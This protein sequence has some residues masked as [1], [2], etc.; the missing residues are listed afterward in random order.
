MGSKRLTPE[1]REAVLRL[2][3][4]GQSIGA[5]ARQAGVSRYSASGIISRA[6]ERRRPGSKGGRP[7]TPA[8]KLACIVARYRAGATLTEA[9]AGN[10][11][12]VQTAWLYLKQLG[13][14]RKRGAPSESDASALLALVRFGATPWE[15]A[16]AR[17]LRLGE[18]LE[19]L[20]SRNWFARV[21][22]TGGAIAACFNPAVK[23]RT[24][25]RPRG[26]GRRASSR[27]AV[28]RGSG[29]ARPGRRPAHRAERFGRR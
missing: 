23:P 16:R 6:G 15:A 2:W 28:R 4:E 5:C 1:K 21:V 8:E 18:V 25:T 7:S 17:R 19:L 27:R 20:R 10:C 24:P 14:L 9:A 13:L 26:A 29:R 12:S 22:A 11:G 3:G